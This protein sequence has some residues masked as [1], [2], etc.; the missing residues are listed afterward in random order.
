MLIIVNDDM[1]T[2]SCIPKNPNITVCWHQSDRSVFAEGFPCESKQKGHQAVKLVFVQQMDWALL[3]WLL[4]VDYTHRETGWTRA[5]ETSSV[6]VH[7]NSL[8]LPI[9]TTTWLSLFIGSQNC[10]FEEYPEMFWN[11]FLLAE[12][13]L[14][15]SSSKKK[16]NKS[17]YIT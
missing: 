17:T 14:G 15:L 7:K 1:V 12:W 16:H 11:V 3:E 8:N 9:R 6:Q 4:C 5:A 10:N 2:I 13:G